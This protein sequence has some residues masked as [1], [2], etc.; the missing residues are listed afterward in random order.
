MAWQYLVHFVKG[1]TASLSEHVMMFFED[2]IRIGNYLYVRTRGYL[3]CITAEPEFETVWK[4]PLLLDQRMGYKFYYVAGNEHAIITSVPV[5]DHYY[6]IVAIDPVN[7]TLLW[8]KHIASAMKDDRNSFLWNER[9]C[10][11]NRKK[12]VVII[13]NSRNGE[14]LYTLDFPHKAVDQQQCGAWVYLSVAEGGGQLYR[15][16]I[17]EEQPCIELVADDIVTAPSAN[18]VSFFCYSRASNR[19]RWYDSSIGWVRGECPVELNGPVRLEAPFHAYPHDVLVWSDDDRVLQ[20]MNI[21]TGDVRWTK[22]FNANWY[23]ISA[24]KSLHGWWITPGFLGEEKH[25]KSTWF[26]ERITG[27]C[28]EYPAASEKGW[29]SE[30]RE[31]GDL[32]FRNERLGNFGIFQWVEED[33][34]VKG[35]TPL[36]VASL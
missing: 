4:L 6:R 35:K 10:I 18:E 1:P 22:P 30:H 19:I 32:V 9:L 24:R 36:R 12:S 16:N 3:V 7:K 28:Y 29:G 13:C 25:D 20:C 5:D 14:T 33:D 8:E 23:F 17:T 27:D 34:W 26:I 15:L 11:I 21:K 31:S 2:V